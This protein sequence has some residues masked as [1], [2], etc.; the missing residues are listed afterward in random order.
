VMSSAL[1]AA[2]ILSTVAVVKLAVDK[3][4]DWKLWM[5]RS[6]LGGAQSLVIVWGLADKP[7]AAEYSER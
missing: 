1:L 4:R 5:A 2:N 7:I 6:I 3:N